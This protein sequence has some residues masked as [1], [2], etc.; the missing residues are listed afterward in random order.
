MKRASVSTLLA[1]QWLTIALAGGAPFPVLA[2][3]GAAPV[4]TN[5]TNRTVAPVKAG[6]PAT[7]VPADA[8]PPPDTAAP[9]ATP[10]QQAALAGARSATPAPA[11][12]TLPTAPSAAGSLA[13]T[14]L[15]LV[16]VLAILMGLA[17]MLRRFGPKTL[18]GGSTVK[19]VGALSVGTRE[20]ILVVEVGDQWIVVG[21]SPGRMNALAQ[22]P[23]QEVDPADLARQQGLP[24]SNFA[25]WFKQTVDKRNGK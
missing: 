17:W 22:L 16:F 24:A 19:L 14:V 5:P 20:R 18:T 1:A 23:R 7:V 25:E 8:A 6:E 12:A 15:A 2:Q 10:E 3:T 21:A 11:A 13:Q 9:A 4:V